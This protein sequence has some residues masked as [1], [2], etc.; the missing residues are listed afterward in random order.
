MPAS[1]GKGLGPGLYTSNWFTRGCEL[2]TRLRVSDKGKK[3]RDYDRAR[4]NEFEKARKTLKKAKTRF[5][6][7]KK[8]YPKDDERF[9]DEESRFNLSQ[10]KFGR[11]KIIYDKHELNFSLKY[12]R[13]NLEPFQIRVFANFVMLFSFLVFF[14]IDS[15]IIVAFFLTGSFLSDMILF[16]MGVVT[17]LGPPIIANMILRYPMNKARKEQIKTLGR[18]P[19]TINYM[20]MSMYL[21]PSLNTA[22]EFASDNVEE[23]LATNLKKILWNVYIR[24]FDSIEESF[25]DFAYFCG[26][27][28]E[29]FKRALYSIRNA[30]IEKTLEGIH[31][32]LDTANE[33]ILEGTKRQMEGFANSLTAPTMVLFSI[34]IILPMIIGALLPLLQVGK[35]SLPLII[36]LMDIVFPVVTFLYAYHILGSRPGTS[37]PPKIPNPLSRRKYTFIIVTSVLIFLAGLVIGIVWIRSLGSESDSLMRSL[38]PLPIIWGFGL[39]IV[40]FAHRTS[41][42]Q[43]GKREVILKMEEEFPDALYHLGSRIAEGKAFED[44]LRT[45][46]KTMEGTFIGRLYRQM[47]YNLQVVRST[48][49][50]ALFGRMGVLHDMPSRTIQATMGTV[51]ESVKKDASTAGATIIKISKYLRD[52]KSVEKEI[53][54]K[55]SG[56]RSMML[57]TGA[58]FGPLIMG[59][60]TALYLMLT[61][62]ISGVGNLGGNDTAMEGVGAFSVGFGDAG[63]IPAE[64]FSLIIGIYLML[65]A[66]VIIY[67]C[68]NI[69]YGDDR[70][71][72]KVAFARTL[73]VTLVVFS[74]SVI[75]ANMMLV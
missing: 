70:V 71:E 58:I 69:K 39:A 14:G 40:N 38:A 35:N 41:R 5:L 64:I 28:S 34:G 23:P 74:L 65:T 22:I 10:E 62:N 12:L 45:T 11:A 21:N 47:F 32:A 26:E 2:A 30:A 17:L 53:D 8:R 20:S 24:Q 15:L 52:L 42:H 4:D 1:D 73:P 67:F 27:F 19:E 59:I 3:K 18:L 16:M 33:I 25:L 55:L 46:S 75:I 36:I 43:K 6:E 49:K 61:E 7:A 13:Y 37:I 48:L 31:R 44:S 57:T 54:N 51:V 72:V 29:E 63:A 60:T 56:I 66:L 68:T 9:W 50:D